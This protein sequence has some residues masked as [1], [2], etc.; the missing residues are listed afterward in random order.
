M[1]AHRDGDNYTEVKLND[2]VHAWSQDAGQWRIVKDH[3][4]YAELVFETKRMRR[5]DLSG[6]KKYRVITEHR[7]SVTVRSSYR[8]EYTIAESMLMRG[9][10]VAS[11]KDLLA[12]FESGHLFNLARLDAQNKARQDGATSLQ[13]I[14]ADDVYDWQ[15]D[16]RTDWEND[17]M[18]LD[19]HIRLLERLPK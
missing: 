7:V 18:R 2:S 17:R 11:V 19:K 16:S 6:R 8:K 9:G 5:Q 12:W 14:E 15:Y 4:V 3:S 1:S 13:M 10:E